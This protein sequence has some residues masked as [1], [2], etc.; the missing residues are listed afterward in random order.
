MLVTLLCIFELLVVLVIF[1]IVIVKSP[2]RLNSVADFLIRIRSKNVDYKYT[3]MYSEF[4]NFCL[5]LVC[6]LIFERIIRSRDNADGKPLAIREISEMSQ[7]FFQGLVAQV[8]A[9]MGG[10]MRRRFY[11]FYNYS[12][13]NVT[14]NLTTASIVESYVLIIVGRIQM[15]TDEVN[16]R[17]REAVAN[18]R[19]PDFGNDYVYSQ[20]TLSIANDINL[21]KI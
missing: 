3:E 14:L 12:T 21:L 1:G 19:N 2:E 10:E 9:T 4:E 13:D 15:F 16:K 17:N 20:L 18:N 5:K 11:M 8:I 6:R 7:P